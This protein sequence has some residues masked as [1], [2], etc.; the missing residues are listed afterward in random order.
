MRLTTIAVISVCAALIAGCAGTAQ[1]DVSAAAATAPTGS[2]FSKALHKEYVA[3]AKRELAEADRSSAE[4]Y[5]KKALAA[6]GGQT[7]EPDDFSKYKVWPPYEKELRGARSALV[8]MLKDP[9]A[10]ANPALAAKAQAN[11]DCWMQEAAEPW[12]QPEDVAFCKNNYQS[13]MAALAAKKAAAKPA[14]KA[15]PVKIL[16]F[17]DFDSAKLTPEALEIVKTAA[18]AAKK[19]KRKRIALTG[20]ADRAGPAEY[21]LKLSARRADTVKAA[22]VKLGIPAGEITTE[23]KGETDPL[24]P[25]ADGVPEPQNR[26]VEIL[27]E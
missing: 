13:A 14:P 11:F 15:Q 6:A 16:V 9:V 26:R 3:I 12:W 1:K 7:V 24:V 27:L 20:H 5:S 17:F 19:G 22:L 4:Y 18:D 2:T 21:N 10:A 8:E 25:T 23:A